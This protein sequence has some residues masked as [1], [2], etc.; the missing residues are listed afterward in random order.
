MLLRSLF[1]T[2]SIESQK[3]T[4]TSKIYGKVRREMTGMQ[5]N[6]GCKL[7]SVI[8]STIS[9]PPLSKPP[10]NV[11]AALP[12]YQILFVSASPHHQ[13]SIPPPALHQG[14]PPCFCPV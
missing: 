8:L 9:T 3:S 2:E 4:N 7:S 12:L 14:T 13:R 10:Y 11:P 6:K 1:A 5:E